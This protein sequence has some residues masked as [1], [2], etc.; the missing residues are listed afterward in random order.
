MFWPQQVGPFCQVFKLAPNGEPPITFEDH[1]LGRPTFRNNG[2]IAWF[3]DST[4]GGVGYAIER[5]DPGG[6]P[7]IVEFSS[8]NHY[9]DPSTNPPICYTPFERVGGK[10]FGISSTGQTIAY[11]TFYQYGYPTD[12]PFEVS[13]IGKLPE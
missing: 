6:S 3:Q 7:A 12:R 2:T 1:N 5:Q 13:D 9:C 8:R 10:Y 11:Y 4:G